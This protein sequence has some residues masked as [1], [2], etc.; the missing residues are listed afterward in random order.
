M[1]NAGTSA[2]GNPATPQRGTRKSQYSTA[3]HEFDCALILYLDKEIDLGRYPHLERHL[4][5][6]V[7]RKAMN[8]RMPCQLPDETVRTQP[9]DSG[10]G[11]LPKMGKPLRKGASGYNRH[12][13]PIV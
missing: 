5:M 4:P 10:R 6:V 9:S 1:E 11:N 8:N 2:R 3:D 7:T 13:V 12:S